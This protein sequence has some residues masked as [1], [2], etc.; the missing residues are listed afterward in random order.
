MSLR[1]L[2]LAVLVLAAVVGMCAPT[3]AEEM[4]GAWVTAWTP[5]FFTAEQVDATVR[6]AK[7]A[8]LNALFIQVR[9]NADAYYRSDTE[10]LGD[11][12]AAGFDPLAC[13]IE[14]AHAQGIQVHAWMNSG[15]IW[16]SKSP[17]TDP[18]H[19]GVRHPEWLNRDVNGNTR[20][21]EGLYLDLGIPGARDYVASVAQEIARK[22]DVDGIHLDYI[23]Y[24]GKNWGYSDAALACYYRDSG[25]TKKPEVSDARFLQWKRDRVTDLVRLVRSKVRSVKPGVA[26]T[27]STIPWGDCPAEWTSTS[28][29]ASVSQDWRRW[30]ADGL[31]EANCPMNYK[32]EKSAKE[33]QQFRNWLAGFKRWSSGKPTYVGLDVGHNQAEDIARQIEAVRKAKLDGFILFQFNQT[34]RR[35]ALAAALRNGPCKASPFADSREAFDTGVRYAAAGRLSLAKSYLEQAVGIDPQNAEAHFRL[36]RCY[37]RERDNARAKELFEKTL[38]LDPKHSGAAK[39]LRALAKSGAG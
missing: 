6:A 33:A 28:P 15:R 10:P 3:G 35:E 11:G 34:S 14:K 17:P 4:R 27:A 13:V 16:S 2:S 36:G 38:A 9:K 39:E 25:V 37:L 26:I 29:Y 18:K 31:L 32:S 8:G 20:A 5:G 30:M 22:Y 21:S 12:V 7:S 23:R 1:N 24:P 19:I